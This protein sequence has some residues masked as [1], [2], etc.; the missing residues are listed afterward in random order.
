[1]HMNSFIASTLL[2]LLF[3]SI[4]EKEEFLAP[5]FLSLLFLS[6]SGRRL[7]K[8]FIVS[9]AI[10]VFHNE[11]ITALSLELALLGDKK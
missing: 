10:A 9:P 11:L 7:P 2:A 4:I 3:L 1:M 6:I 5:F 8:Y